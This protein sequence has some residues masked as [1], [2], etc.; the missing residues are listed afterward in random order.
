MCCDNA[1]TLLVS[2]SSPV[3]L[4]PRLLVA[5]TLP[6]RFCRTTEMK[7][8]VVLFRMLAV[9][10]TATGVACHG[11]DSTEADP[12]ADCHGLSSRAAR[13][14]VWNA[15]G[16]LRPQTFGSS[17]LPVPYSTTMESDGQV[18]RVAPIYLFTDYGA[19]PPLT[20]GPSAPLKISPAR[21]ARFCTSMA[22]AGRRL[23][24]VSQV[25]SSA[26][27]EPHSRTCGRWAVPTLATKSRVMG[28][29][30]FTSTVRPGRECKIQ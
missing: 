14:K 21:P 15:F 24:P 16:G 29:S 27:G 13:P 26:Y 3:R 2:R 5:M 28:A 18:S 10:T 11:T 22:R 7:L 17:E 20:S 6:E 9:I 12:G 8:N 4:A 30:S 25:S 1:L 19:A 23:P